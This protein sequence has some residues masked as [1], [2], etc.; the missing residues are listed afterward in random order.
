MVAS[1]TCIHNFIPRL[2]DVLL[3]VLHAIM[4]L[5]PGNKQSYNTHCTCIQ[6][7]ALW[8]CSFMALS[9]NFMVDDIHINSFSK[10]V[11]CCSHSY[12]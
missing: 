1:Y 10:S 12:E 8:P 5:E 11:F 7:H 9:L 6:C 3:C 2:F 4:R